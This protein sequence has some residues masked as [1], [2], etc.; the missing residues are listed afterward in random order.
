ML[1]HKINDFI[2]D[3]IIYSII[4]LMVK[5]TLCKMMKWTDHKYNQDF[6]Q[7]FTTHW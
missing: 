3:F 4:K 5:R 2:I 1:K 6:F 7:S